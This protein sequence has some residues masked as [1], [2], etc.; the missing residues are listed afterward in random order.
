[1]RYLFTRTWIVLDGAASYTVIFGARFPAGSPITQ[2]LKLA[3]SDC[4]AR[5]HGSDT[6][7]SN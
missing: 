7:Y 2:V 5:L 3:L 1:M 6:G 4:L